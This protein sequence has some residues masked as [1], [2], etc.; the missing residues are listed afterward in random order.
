[1]HLRSIF[2]PI[3]VVCISIYLAS[4][5]VSCLKEA[6]APTTLISTPQVSTSSPKDLANA[7][8]LLAS[9]PGIVNPL[10]QDWPRE[11]EGMNGRISIPSKPL[12]IHTI[13][14]GHEETV[15]GLVPFKRIVGVRPFTQ[16]PVYSN[17]ASLAENIEVIGRS[18]EQILARNPDIVIASPFA[19]EE[20][21]MALHSVGI[22]VLQM[23]LRNDPSGRVEDILFLGYA[24]G[25]EQRALEL[26]NEVQQ[27]Y[28]AVAE[29]A[30]SKSIEERPRVLSVT[31]YS[32]K[33][34]VAGN[35][36]TEGNIIETSGGINVAAVA[37]IQRNA[38]TNLEGII[39]MNPEIIII[40]QPVE[41]GGMEFRDSLLNNKSLADLP[42]VLERNVFLVPARFFTTLSFWNIRGA[43]EL[44][45][46]LWPEDLA[47]R[48][49]L[50]FS[51]PE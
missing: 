49:F 12:R 43:E 10:N 36:S 27:R 30:A 16:N 51:F 18:P 19:K 4:F 1:M 33:L 46:L 41:D 9:V 50:Q 5:T 47:G 23:E 15:F 28:L 37:G 42:A 14:L 45:K 3:I 44:S 39:A 22:S 25:E 34:Y 20:L 7:K 21:I 29:I 6:V 32:D 2:P 13:S 11:V 24:L 8:D 40:P 31:F 35:N 17:V 38:I 48:E 26:V